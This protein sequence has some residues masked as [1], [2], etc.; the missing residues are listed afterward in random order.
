MLLACIFN[1]THLA[2]GIV[3]TIVCPLV[4]SMWDSTLQSIQFTGYESSAE[5][6]VQLPVKVVHIRDVSDYLSINPSHAKQDSQKVGDKLLP[7]DDYLFIYIYCEI[8]ISEN[9]DLDKVSGSMCYTVCPLGNLYEVAMQT[10]LKA[11]NYA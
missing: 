11:N 2:K 5:H 8:W 10:I 1:Y 6:F 4:G 3:V 7:K 9:S